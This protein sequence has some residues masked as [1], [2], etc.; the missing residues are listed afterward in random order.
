MD[1]AHHGHVSV[2]RVQLHV[3]LLVDQSLAVVVVVHAD[4]R[5][6]GD[7]FFKLGVRK[8]FLKWRR[9]WKKYLLD[10][11]QVMRHRIVLQRLVKECWRSGPCRSPFI[12][13]WSVDRFHA[14]LPDVSW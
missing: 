5:H 9:G 2:G 14:G 1:E 8:K 13:E 6:L 11:T 10:N 7:D 12:V 4:R 3:D